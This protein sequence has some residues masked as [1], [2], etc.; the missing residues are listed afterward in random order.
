MTPGRA[1]MAAIARR[2]AARVGQLRVALQDDVAAADALVDVDH[3]FDQ[4]FAVHD[5]NSPEAAP[6]D[7]FALLKTVAEVAN[8]LAQRNSRFAGRQAVVHGRRGA[9]HQALPSSIGHDRGQ[10]VAGKSEHQDG[11]ARAA[12]GRFVD[13]EAAFEPR[14]A[15]AGDDR[16][17]VAGELAHGRVEPVF[18][19]GGHEQSRVAHAKRLGESVLDLRSANF[20]ACNSGGADR[21][22]GGLK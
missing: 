9:G 7:Q 6:A 14:L 13:R 5:R 22:N 20:H 10:R 21:H 12:V 16:R 4:E 1:S 17:T 8:R 15:V 3:V 18:V 2:T 19:M 11:G